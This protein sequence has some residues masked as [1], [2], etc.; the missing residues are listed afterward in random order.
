M[1][2]AS[3]RTAVTPERQG[4]EPAY[5]EVMKTT[6]NVKSRLTSLLTL[7]LEPPNVPRGPKLSKRRFNN[8]TYVPR[9][10]YAVGS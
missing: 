4:R 2:E 3:W 1:R 8:N 7:C 5:S 6:E 10:V 9:R